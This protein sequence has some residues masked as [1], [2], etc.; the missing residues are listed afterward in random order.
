MNTTLSLRMMTTKRKMEVHLLR[1]QPDSHSLEMET[2]QHMSRSPRQQP[3][4]K[5]PATD[6]NPEDVQKPTFKEARIF[7]FR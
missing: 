5:N 6:R 4:R 2:E 7:W 3:R 1:P